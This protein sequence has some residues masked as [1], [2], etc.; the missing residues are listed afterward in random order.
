MA[1]HTDITLTFL[2]TGTSTG[3]PML[4]CT[5]AVCASEDSRD[6]RLR[7]SVLVQK[8]ST[9]LLIDTGPD[10]RTQLLRLG[11]CPDVAALLITH[12]HRDHLAGLDDVRAL[13]FKTQKPMPVYADAA[14]LA[15]IRKE[16]YYAQ[17]DGS[18]PAKGLSLQLNEVEAAP[19]GVQDLEV[20]PLRLQHGT[21]PILGFLF[22]EKK[23]A[24][25]T[26]TK[27]IP[28]ST[29]RQLQG[30]EVLILTALRFAPPHR[31]HMCVSEALAAVERI[32]PKRTYFTHL[33]HLIG[34]HEEIEKLLP[35]SVFFAYDTLVITI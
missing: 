5:C 15:V 8:K 26:D 29:M 30:V 17:T 22:G 21:L 10:F 3:V 4:G 13:V 31:A 7:A 9:T 23:V 16:F 1:L 24:Y 12:F 34:R 6:K 2:G 11:K 33:S 19:F 25:L 35:P 27:Y 20:M 32:K 14:T 18:E 28:E